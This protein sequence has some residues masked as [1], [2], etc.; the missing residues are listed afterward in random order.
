MGILTQA[1]MD[2]VARIVQSALGH[3]DTDG[4]QETVTYAHREHQSSVAE[5]HAGLLGYISQYSEA[6]IVEQLA[7]T[8]ETTRIMREDRKLRI[9]TADVTWIPTLSGSVIRE[10]GTAWRVM[11]IAGG[12]GKP[13]YRFRLRKLP[14]V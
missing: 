5:S 10:D 14:G 6:V 8:P 12:R 13:F 4:L 2:A 1:T 11:D 3:A 7:L 9:A